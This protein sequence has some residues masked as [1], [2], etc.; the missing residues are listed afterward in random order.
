[1]I[2]A[3]WNRKYCIWN[4]NASSN[5]WVCFLICSWRAAD[6]SC[7]ELLT[8]AESGLLGG[9]TLGGTTKRGLS[10]TSSRPEA[11]CSLLLVVTLALASCKLALIPPCPV[12]PQT[13]GRGD[14]EGSAPHHQLLK[15]LFSDTVWTGLAS[16]TFSFSFFSSFFS[17]FTKI[18]VT[19]LIG[20]RKVFSL[21]SLI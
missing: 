11:S 8:R 4:S 16:L 19:A 3:L 10:T 15:L 12:S 6:E 7:W 5:G 2:S 14:D 1:M 9:C 17:L 18:K 20:F 21:L 13:R